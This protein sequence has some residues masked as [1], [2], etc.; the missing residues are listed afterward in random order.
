LVGVFTAAVLLVDEV[1]VEAVF[2]LD[3]IRA[4]SALFSLPTVMVLEPPEPQPAS[5]T[6]IAASAHHLILATNR[7]KRSSIFPDS[8]LLMSSYARPRIGRPWTRVPQLAC[9]A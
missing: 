4:L 5:A 2:S 3:L 6:A 8:D 7:Y 9:A 1:E